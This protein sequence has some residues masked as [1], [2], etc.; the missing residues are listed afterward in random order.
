[1]P[2]KIHSARRVREKRREVASKG[3][4]MT[5]AEMSRVFM[6]L[7]R[8]DGHEQAKRFIV[9]VFNAG[10]ENGHNALF[11]LEIEGNFLCSKRFR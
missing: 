9:S 5:K 8:A 3:P 7:N 11:V 1:M 4:K 6:G 2:T 10:R